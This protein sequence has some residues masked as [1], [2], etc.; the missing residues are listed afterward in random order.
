MKKLGRTY[1]P[2]VYDGAGHG[3]L[4]AQTGRDGANL[5][6]TQ[7]AWPRTVGFLREHL[8]GRSALAGPPAAPPVARR[9]AHAVSIHGETLSDD[10]SWLRNKGTPEVESYLNAELAYARAFMKPT[11]AL[12]QKLYDEMLSRIQQTDVN[13]PYLDR[14]YF[15]YSRTEEGKQYPIFCRKKGSTEAPSGRAADAIDERRRI[16]SGGAEEEVILDVNQLAVGKEFM[17]VDEMAVSPEG[18]R[19][20][21]TTDETGFRQY[22]L[23]VKDLAPGP[24][25]GSDRRHSVA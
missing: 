25:S 22:T 20:A 6:A 8:D 15:Y 24:R 18:S 1:E 14:G 2:H 5:K 11:E 21:Y 4:R 10:Y 16:D 9:V 3:F 19:L 17:S 7:Q 23:H 13:V 12:Q